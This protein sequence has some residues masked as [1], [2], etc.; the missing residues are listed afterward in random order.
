MKK[1]YLVM[2]AICPLAIS[3]MDGKK[4]INSFEQLKKEPV[5]KMAFGQLPDTACWTELKKY[6]VAPAVVGRFM[7]QESDVLGLN[8]DWRTDDF[9]MLSS[10]LEALQKSSAQRYHELVCATVYCAKGLDFMERNKL[11]HLPFALNKSQIFRDY[12]Q[13][14]R[15]EYEAT[16]AD[17]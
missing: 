16:E 13:Q 7:L 1:L 5:W 9:T 8:L 17:E 11:Q 12:I 6:D 14:L 2:I 4:P 15:H 3:G 10:G